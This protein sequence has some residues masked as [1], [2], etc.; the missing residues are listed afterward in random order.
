[1]EIP[2][3]TQTEAKKGSL[4]FRSNF[5]QLQIKRGGEVTEK[6]FFVTMSEQTNKHKWQI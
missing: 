2:P 3:F 5:F 6:V 1:M 4:L